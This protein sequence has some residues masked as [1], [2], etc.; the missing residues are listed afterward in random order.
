MQWPTLQ[1][2]FW[3]TVCKIH[4][5]DLLGGSPIPCNQHPCL[6]RSGPSELGWHPI[7]EDL[8]L[9]VLRIVARTFE[10]WTMCCAVGT[11]QLLPGIQSLFR[12]VSN[13]INEGKRER[14]EQ[15]I[16]DFISDVEV[17]NDIRSLKVVDAV[18]AAAVHTMQVGQ[19]DS[20]SERV[21]SM[22]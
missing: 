12:L 10:H 9:P 6:C 15:Y 16:A 8:D 5:P 4:A 22:T 3:K 21:R 11:W 14:L 17:G 19:D 2:D 20:L 7:I 18:L 1:L 13:T